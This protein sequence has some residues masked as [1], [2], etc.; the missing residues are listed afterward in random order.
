MKLVVLK[1]GGQPGKIAIN[2][3]Q[4][5]EV[6]SSTGPFTDIHFNGHF[7]SVQGSFEQVIALLEGNTEDTGPKRSDW[8]NAPR[9]FP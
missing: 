1:K 5:T 4:V 7:V 2:P 8:F 3:D 9:S 6:R